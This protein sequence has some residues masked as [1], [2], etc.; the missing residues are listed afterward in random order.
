MNDLIKVIKKYFEIHVSSF[1]ISKLNF[2]D[3]FLR[4]HR[5]NLVY[6]FLSKQKK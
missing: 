5:V 1:F 6:L 3:F 2:H 4:I